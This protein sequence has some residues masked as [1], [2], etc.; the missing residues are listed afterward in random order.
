MNKMI[1]QDYMVLALALAQ[2]GRFSVS[3]NPMV[4]CVIVKDNKIIGQGFHRRAGGHHAEIIAL[5]EAKEEARGATVYVTLEPCCH[6]GRTPPCTKSL[7]AAG[8]KCIYIA[9][10][11]PNAYV[12]NK[13]IEAL[14]AANIEVHIGL[15][16]EEAI[17]LNKIFFHYIK[18]KRPFVIA[19]WAMSLD[20][21]TMTHPEDTR[22]ISCVKTQQS[23]HTLRQEVDAILIGA[24][25]AIKDNPLLTARFNTKNNA[26]QP[27]RIIL[28]SKGNIP[29]NLNMFDIDMPSKTI[30]VTTDLV[31]ETWRKQAEEKNITVLV[32]EKN[33]QGQ[34]SLPV[35]LEE[36]GKRQITSLLIEGGREIHDNFIKEELIN[37][38]R[39]YLAPVIIG[40]LKQKC[41]LT[42]THSSQIE[43]DYCF[44][45]EPKVKHV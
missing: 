36:L 43:T 25:T 5:E 2:R 11:D 1:H 45:A 33:A 15:C 19:K 34:V 24:R 16:E 29:L 31:D 41:H 20:G 8:I 23:A 44:S 37:E 39:V 13:G 18:H 14:K 9:C 7:I 32:L 28:S 4:G 35:L 21:K 22:D 38:F 6:Y 12:N 40:K 26:R 10:K 3:P 42:L 17:R 30:V 27:M